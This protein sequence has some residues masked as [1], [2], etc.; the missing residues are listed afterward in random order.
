MSWIDREKEELVLDE[1]REHKAYPDQYKNWTIGIGHLLG[2]DPVFSS[3][4]WSDEQIDQAFLDDTLSALDGV[5]KRIGVFAGLDGPRQGCLLNMAFNMGADK[6]SSF[7]GF[8]GLLD[9]GRYTEAADDLMKTLYAK[10]LPS[11]VGR[12]AYRIKTGEYANR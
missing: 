7:H 10:Q 6:L 12:L 4:V 11:R 8:L 2:K 5:H 3:L 1:G 9:Q